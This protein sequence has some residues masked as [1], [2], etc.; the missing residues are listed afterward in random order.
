[1]LRAPFVFSQHGPV[2]SAQLIR[3]ARRLGLRLDAA[4]LKSLFETGDLA[5]LAV[6]TDGVVGTAA[7]QLV[8]EPPASDSSVIALRLAQTSGRVYDPTQT[9]APPD[10]PLRFDERK[11]AD[12]ANWW[13]GLLYSRW[14]LLNAQRLTRATR[15]GSAG[16]PLA[17]PRSNQEGL[18]DR[19]IA[20]TV[21]LLEPRYLP[22][23]E[24]G[25]TR[26]RGFRQEEW[27]RW[28]DEYDVMRQL[29]FLA[30]IGVALDDV[31]LFAED[32]LFRARRLDP[33][34]QWGALIRRAPI[35][36]WESTK[37]DLAL[38][39]EQRLAAEILLRFYEDAGGASLTQPGHPVTWQ[40]VHDRISDRREPLG[41]LLIRLGV[42]PQPGAIL[43]VEGETERRT[44]ARILDG[45]G[46]DD[47][48][49]LVQIIATRGVD[50]NLQLLAA[51]T[52]APIVGER[53]QDVYD[54]LRPPC[55][56][57]AVVDAEGKYQT[58]PQ[59]ERER[60][61]IVNA[62]VEVVRAQRDDAD[63][64]H[65]DSLVEIRAWSGGTFEFTHYT[66]LE[67]LKAIT[68]VHTDSAG[69]PS[70]ADML[71]RIAQ[72]R[73]RGHDLKAVWHDWAHQPSKPELA[74]VLWPVMSRRIDIALATGQPL[75]EIAQAVY[76]AHE[77]AR[78]NT[79][80]S[81]VLGVNQ[82]PL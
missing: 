25:W 11:M 43:V 41:R 82:A 15:S 17:D 21:T 78:T 44:A 54:L 30:T 50:K 72:S 2:G 48:P 70:D 9:P 52:V 12:P 5:P 33:T 3:D 66:D 1:M 74:D 40:P 47:A 24:P 16:G 68:G 10:E 23:V 14:Q 71:A 28:R 63:L 46:L 57:L 26:V 49:E 53:H 27:F 19:A 61:R 45:V 62:I 29:E 42:S 13:N 65:L 64:D 8:D 6:I 77:R 51:A 81:W 73:S 58:P 36:K 69:R 34:G 79:T 18:R 32:L 67:L 7:T 37:G 35:K 31:H 22:E 56:L 39:L 4:R 55:Y 60:G 80:G 38:A 59:V 20:L 75:P 76:D